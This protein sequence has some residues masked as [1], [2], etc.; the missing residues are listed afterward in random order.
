MGWGTW[1]GNWPAPPDTDGAV[2]PGREAPVEPGAAPAA[3]D[4]SSLLDALLSVVDTASEQILDRPIRPRLKLSPGGL[5]RGELDVVRLE[6]PA[7]L[8]AGLVLD[9]MSLRAER[10]R[11]QPG[12]PPRLRAGPVTLHAVVSQENVDRWTRASH[13]P[14]R[15]RLDSGGITVSTGLGGFRVGELQTRLGVAGR[16]LRLQPERA[17]IV[18]LP[19]PLVRFLRGY[20]PLPPLPR[21]ARLVGVD[22]TEGELTARFRMEDFDEPLTP[23]VALRLART[24]RLPLPGL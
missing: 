17:R 18:G 14:L 4:D 3:P 23:D 21:G 7:V 15:L 24:L 1:D 10:V 12:L 22:H 20:L 2:A 8:A 16:F 13:L 11:L 19:N 5:A 9:R 6:V